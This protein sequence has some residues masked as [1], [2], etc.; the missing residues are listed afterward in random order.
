MAVGDEKIL[1]AVVVVVEEST[2][3]AK[4]LFSEDSG[5]LRNIGKGPISPIFV[6]RIA[7]VVGH[8]DVRIP[9]VVVIGRPVFR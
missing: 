6:Q 5:A 1:V 9:V 3:G 7:A 8:V 2:S 4:C